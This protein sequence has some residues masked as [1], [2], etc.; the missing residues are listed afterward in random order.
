MK[1]LTSPSVRNSRLQSA[2]SLFRPHS[3]LVMSGPSCGQLGSSLVMMFPFGG[4]NVAILFE[5]YSG[6]IGV[7][8]SQMEMRLRASMGNTP[9]GHRS[10]NGSPIKILVQLRR[11]GRQQLLQ[12]LR[13]RH[14]HSLLP[15]RPIARGEDGAIPSRK[16]CGCGS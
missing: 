1:G 4:S 12:P 8:S 15:P 7:A 13:R 5:L 11:L 16:S 9:K 2:H 14:V 3:S 10:P 6:L